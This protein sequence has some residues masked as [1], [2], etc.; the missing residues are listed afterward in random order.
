MKTKIS[1]LFLI[2]LIA[3]FSRFLNLSNFPPAL[4][5]DEVDAGYQALVFNHSQSDYFGNQ[6]PSH[7]HSFSDWRT[8]S[9]I[10]S[11]AFFQKIGF[12]PELSVRLPSAVFGVLSVILIYLI[13]NSP[14][15]S[16]L[17]AISPWAIHYSRTGFEVSGMIMFLLAGIYFWKRYLL[18]HKLSWLLL[19]VIAFVQAPY[20][21][22]TAN[23][24]LPILLLLILIIW[25]SDIKKM[26]PLHLLSGIIL[27]LLLLT[28]LAID[29]FSGQSGFR[30]SYIGIFTQPH[31]EQ[32][33]DH[34]RYEDVLLNHYGEVG[35]KT[36]FISKILHNKYQLVAQKF[37]ENY[38][39]SFSTSFLF[40]KGDD[41]LRH[42]FGGHGLLY[43]LDLFVI[44]LG[45]F[46][47]FKKPT[48]IGSL[49]FWLLILAPIPYSLTRDSLSPHATRL[50]LMLPSLIYF[51]YL[52]LNKK[53]FL[54]PL[55]FLLFL[56]FAHYYTIHY[57]QS[58]AATWHT[59]MKDA[60]LLTSKYPGNDIY[61]SDSFEPFMPFFLFYTPYYSSPSKSLSDQLSHLQN[62][63]FDGT[64]LNNNYYFGHLNMDKIPSTASQVYVITGDE[65]QSLSNK[66]SF[67]IISQTEK[68]YLT[69][70]QFLIITPH[71]QK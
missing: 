38:V 17:L 39:S 48:K 50:I 36:S 6:F 58:S 15:A 23:L 2:L 71:E 19:A 20:F 13:T 47:Y 70:P 56:N 67:D 16:F 41:N 46:I 21:Y 24:F 18:N 22:S 62:D 27:G 34:L 59:G 31:R 10:Y 4:F 35:V 51:S 8:P 68:R 60:I 49:F 45:I 64:A 1:I 63:F 3:V 33:T 12:S 11:I 53:K 5:S 42:G 28:P 25:R 44:P 65:Y 52:G 66:S 7:F 40:L 29:T 26:L 14:L 30:F 54:L 61:F 43:L 32:V 57:P 69:S 9:L 37:V 55:Y